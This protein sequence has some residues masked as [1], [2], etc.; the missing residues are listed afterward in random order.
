MVEVQN[1]LT[2]IAE[3]YPLMVETV[4]VLENEVETMQ[5]GKA[6]KDIVD[7]LNVRIENLEGTAGTKEEIETLDSRLDSLERDTTIMG[8]EVESVKN[9]VYD[10]GFIEVPLNDG[11]IQYGG[12]TYP[13]IRRFGACVNL[14]GAIKFTTLPNNSGTDTHVMKL[15]EQFRPART[16]TICSPMSGGQYANWNIASDGNVTLLTYSLSNVTTNT[17]FPFCF[18]WMV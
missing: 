15:P 5:T 14:A 16:M 6:N 3:T 8:N 1:K 9:A 11:V 13:K 18:N 12:T 10:T 17:W 2:P 7:G 4:S